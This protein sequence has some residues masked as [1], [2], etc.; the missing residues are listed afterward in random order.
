MMPQPE[1]PEPRLKRW[2][3]RNFDTERARHDARVVAQA[4]QDIAQGIVGDAR[5]IGVAL[6]KAV[7]KGKA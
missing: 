5:R 7:R 3:R 6:S 1:Q 2:V 4:A